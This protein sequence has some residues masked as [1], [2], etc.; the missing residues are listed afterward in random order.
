MG[1]GLRAREVAGCKVLERNEMS[2]ELRVRV[3]A[4]RD[5]LGQWRVR[6]WHV[7]WDLAFPYLIRAVHECKQ[8]FSLRRMQ[9]ELCRRFK[10]L[11]SS[12][13]VL[14]ITDS[15]KSKCINMQL[16]TFSFNSNFMSIFIII[17][18]KSEE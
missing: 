16:C 8:A 6:D 18:H 4:K 3:V 15:A 1:S 12:F 13:F 5:A 9:I 7:P 17:H 11:E 14:L 2:S 10:H